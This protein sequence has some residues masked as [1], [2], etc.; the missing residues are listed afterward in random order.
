MANNKGQ[1]FELPYC[2][3]NEILSQSNSYE[4]IHKTLKPSQNPTRKWLQ[5]TSIVDLYSKA[6]KFIYYEKK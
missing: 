1:K 2:L 5:L 4:K 6:L 3:K